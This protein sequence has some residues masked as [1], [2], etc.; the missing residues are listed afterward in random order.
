MSDTTKTRHC[1]QCEKQLYGRADQVY[2]ND[3]C[4][5]TFNKQKEKQAKTPPHPKEKEIFAIIRRNY[6]ILKR[7]TPKGI[8]P[9]HELTKSFDDLP[10]QFNKNFFTGTIETKEGIWF[11]CFDR[12]WQEKGRAIVM[13]D[14]P[15]ILP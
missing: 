11:L 9:G 14:F 7:F 10:A 2:C 5:N 8:H 6:D 12:G 15:E 4:R 1:K 3:T 13:K